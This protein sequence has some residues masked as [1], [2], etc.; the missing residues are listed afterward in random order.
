MYGAIIRVRI[1]LLI[2]RN[3]CFLLLY[4]IITSSSVFMLTSLAFESGR[5]QKQI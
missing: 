4:L 5:L 2:G 1:D 3:S